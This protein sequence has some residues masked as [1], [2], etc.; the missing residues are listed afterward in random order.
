M[1]WLLFWRHDHHFHQI[2]VN[3]IDSCYNH[4]FHVT[5]LF[6]VF[7]LC[8]YHQ[9]HGVLVRWRCSCGDRFT[10]NCP[11]LVLNKVY[12]YY[13]YYYYC[14]SYARD[15]PW[16]LFVQGHGCN[17]LLDQSKHQDNMMQLM[18]QIRILPYMHNT[19]QIMCY[20]NTLQAMYHTKTL[21]CKDKSYNR[22]TMQ[23]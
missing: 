5:C 20:A 2:I 15:W 19:M 6:Y 7:V 9:Y 22:C 14:N 1:C 11:I 10:C 17:F 12:Y 16:F 18:Y 4:Q 8:H 13:Y 3:L 21:P 23:G